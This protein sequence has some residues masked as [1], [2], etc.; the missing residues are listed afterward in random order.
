MTS[1]DTDLRDCPG[2][3]SWCFTP[4]Y[5]YSGRDQLT[6]ADGTPIAWPEGTLARARISWG[7]GTEMIV[8]ATI[9][10]SW[11]VVALTPEQTTQLPRG[12][13]MTIDTAP[14]SD[15]TGWIPWRSGR[16]TR[17]R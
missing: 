6:A 13:R 7:T 9:D 10:D 5:A 16:S 3:L 8:T 17:C 14:A 12:A 15:P 4:G 1:P 11:V 2:P